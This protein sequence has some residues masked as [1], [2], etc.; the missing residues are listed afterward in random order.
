LV[1]V[2]LRDQPGL[3]RPQRPETAGQRQVL[4]GALRNLAELLETP[5]PAIG[6][7]V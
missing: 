2:L 4:E 3:D 7:V 1:Y 5:P 6:S